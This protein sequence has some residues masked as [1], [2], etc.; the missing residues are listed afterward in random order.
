MT[1]ISRLLTASSLL[2]AACACTAI[3]GCASDP[4]SGYAFESS[5]ASGVSSVR[6]PVFENDTFARGIEVELAEALA[7]EVRTRTP[8]RIVQNETAQS[9]LTGRIVSAE[10]ARI[11]TGR[12]TGLVEEQAYTLTVDFTFTDN[13]TGKAL[14][15]RRSFRAASTFVPTRGTTGSINERIEVGQAGTVQELARRIVDQ[16]RSGW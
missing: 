13:R 6:L 7:H 12:D 10:L 15:E 1:P 14:V 2:I 16:L 4:R 3:L 5:F 8:W 11:S 9:T